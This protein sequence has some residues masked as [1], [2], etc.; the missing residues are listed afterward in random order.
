MWHPEVQTFEV[1]DKVSSDLVG[2]FYMVLQTKIRKKEKKKT[3]ETRKK[4]ER[5]NKETRKR[6]KQ[7]TFQC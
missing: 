4:Q 3:K 5:N 7:L 1:R 6:E 2:H